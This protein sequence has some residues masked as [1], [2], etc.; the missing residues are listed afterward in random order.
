MAYTPNIPNAGD[1]IADSQPQLKGNFQA[2]KQ[3]I[4][5]N[6]GTFGS[7]NEGKHHKV[8]FPVQSPTPTFSAGDLGLYSFLNP[9]TNKNE[10]YCHKIQNATTAEVPLT[11]SILSSATPAQDTGGW[12]YLPSGIYMSFGS[13]N[14]NGLTTITLGNHPPNQ[15]LSVMVCPKANAITYVNLQVRL[16]DV[17]NSSQFRIFVSVNGVAA[18]GGFSFIVMGY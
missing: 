7:A 15:I 18:A 1:V 5:V 6:H 12:T 16:I 10:L 11:A 17:L 14:G 4:D 3:L 2:V 9:T 8:S 13:A